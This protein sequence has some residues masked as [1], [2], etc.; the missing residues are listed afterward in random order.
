MVARLAEQ[1]AA[2]GETAARWT[3]DL[4]RFGVYE[5]L[6]IAPVVEFAPASQS[7][8]RTKL[9]LV[10]TTAGRP[11]KASARG[12]LEPLLGRTEEQLLAE[13]KRRAELSTSASLVPA[14]SR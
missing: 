1:D 11:L 2:V 12:W 5:P 9:K 8:P 10:A 13:I 6:V 3:A 14:P 4:R 7:F